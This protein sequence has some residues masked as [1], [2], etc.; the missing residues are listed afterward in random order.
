MNSVVRVSAEKMKRDG[1]KIDSYIDNMQADINS[2]AEAMHDLAVCWEGPAW[3]T[4]QNSVADSI[5]EMEGVCKFLS[6]FITDLSKAESIYRKC[7][8]ENRTIIGKIRI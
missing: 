5:T 6:T 4:F 1:I 2:L 8:N 3:N 7:E